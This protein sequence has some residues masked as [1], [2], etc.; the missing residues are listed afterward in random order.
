M[1]HETFRILIVDDSLFNREILRRILRED[2]AKMGIAPENTRYEF[3]TADCGEAALTSVENDHPDLMLM[4]IVMPGISGFEVLER[5]Q[6]NA[7]SKNMPVIVVSGL[8]SE[9][10]EEKSFMLGAV[11]FISKPFANTIVTARIKTHLRIIEQ[12]R[13]IERISLSD[14]LTGLPNRRSFDNR[15]TLSW[16]LAIRD[17]APIAAIMIDIDFF[18]KFNDNYGHQQGDVTL[19]EVGAAIESVV[20]RPLDFAARW[21]GEE[22]VVLLPNTDLPG[23]IYMAEQIRLKI[24]S[25]QVPRLD[26]GEPLHV[27]ASLGVCV[28]TPTPDHSV[29]AFLKHADEA[30]YAAKA[31]GRNRVCVSEKSDGTIA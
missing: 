25:T 21:G 14:Q 19:I 16:K 31:Q 4:D 12:M 18:K 20:K 30:L 24:A 26:G 29:E 6:Q 11:D 7:M 22:F 10:D 13:I 28:W 9:N 2:E 5:L 3:I 1:Q 27:T 8:D 15:M 23:A 17:K